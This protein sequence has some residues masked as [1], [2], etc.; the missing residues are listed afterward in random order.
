MTDTMTVTTET[1]PMNG[2]RPADFLL[3]NREMWIVF[4]VSQQP[5]GGWFVS[6]FQPPQNDDDGGWTL[7][8]AGPD[9]TVERI[10]SLR[11]TEPTDA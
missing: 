5:T 8:T 3:L 4:D 9:A 6:L 7:M 10:T 11:R 2:V 1:V